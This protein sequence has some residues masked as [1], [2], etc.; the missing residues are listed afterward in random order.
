MSDIEYLRKKKK[1]L[2][3]RQEDIAAMIAAHEAQEEQ[4]HQIALRGFLNRMDSIIRTASSSFSDV[5][6]GEIHE[7]ETTACSYMRTIEVEISGRRIENDYIQSVGVEH[8]HKV[9]Y[10]DNPT[11][12]VSYLIP[13]D[14]ISDDEFFN[15][16]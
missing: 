7:N 9:S 3:E 10:I 8:L 13:Y 11:V 4:D 6:I 16:S 1:E 2:E 5:S 14:M 12:V 15:K